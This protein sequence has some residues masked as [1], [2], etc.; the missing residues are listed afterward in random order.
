MQ[1]KH[2]LILLVACILETAH[3]VLIATSKTW[4]H[5]KNHKSKINASEEMPAS[6]LTAA[7]K[8]V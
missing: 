3:T 2:L 4:I 7:S 6:P 1:A 8:A 5:N